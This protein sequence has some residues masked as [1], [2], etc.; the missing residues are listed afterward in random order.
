M[1]AYLWQ[2]K[3]LEKLNINEAEKFFNSIPKEFSENPKI[4]SAKA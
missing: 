1:D 2:I 3:I 4:L